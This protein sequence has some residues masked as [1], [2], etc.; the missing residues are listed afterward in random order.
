MTKKNAIL[1]TLLFCLPIFLL[2]Q[3]QNRPAKITWGK[4]TVE[5]QNTS[6][7]KIVSWNKESF[8]AIR[9]KGNDVHGPEGPTKIYLER[10]DKTMNL[11]KSKELGLKFKKK[12]RQYEDIMMIG[13]QLYLFSSFNNQAKKKNYLFAQK[14]SLKGL[15]PE[16]DLKFIA[17]IDTKNKVNEGFFNFH[18]SRDSSKFLVYSERP[19]KKNKP[20]QLSIR[21][22][23]DQMLELW[24]KDIVL[25][26]DDNKFV[27]EDY[28]VSNDGKVY[29]LGVLY[30][31]AARVRRGGLPNYKYVILAYNSTNP[32]PTK[33]KID[34]NEKFITDLTFR[35]ADN[36]EL[37]CSGFYS[38]VGT[39]SIKGTYFFRVD[40]V[41][42]RIFNKNAKELAFDFRTEYISDKKKDK[43]KN[44]EKKGNNKKA[45]ELYAY[46]LDHLIL[47]NDGGALLIAEQYFVEE[48]NQDRYYGYR[49]DYYNR[50]YI[51]EYIYNYNDIIIVNI[52]PDGDVEWTTR[53]PKRQVTRNDGGYFSSYAMSI[54][55][56][57]IHFI[58]NDNARNYATDRKQ[59]RFYNYNGRN[60]IIALSTVHQ[61]GT[62][63]TYPL[64][65]N[66]E[67]KII[68]RPK[69]CRQIG[70]KE[71]A[72]YGERGRYSRFGKLKF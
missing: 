10:Y 23:D 28:R 18:I 65:E 25:P 3:T 22:F 9:L 63:M 59:N 55:R 35:I 53:I 8:Y 4:E 7:E 32:K 33:Y 6:L 5:P 19:R 51:N 60:S 27:L 42:K 14:V 34:L 41:E 39:Y 48:Y 54:V 67:A 50:G 57:K 12:R 46:S 44:S 71:M 2:A 17:E 24:S 38:D 15:Q 30:Q 49:Y 72:V 45:G 11:V 37:I 40:P 47:R 68:T 62:V 64:F 29:L 1:L 26:Y 69:I 43:I 31:D 61:D 13:R 56:D 21:V 20:E 16:Q 52:K 36:G 66:R 58:Y 70:R